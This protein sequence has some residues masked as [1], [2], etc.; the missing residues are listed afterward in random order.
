MKTVYLKLNK[1][2]FLNLK[3]KKY[4]FWYFNPIDKNNKQ[5]KRN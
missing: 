1:F 4:K 5:E 2:L 3:N